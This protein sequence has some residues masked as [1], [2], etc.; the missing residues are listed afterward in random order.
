MSLFRVRRS[1]GPLLAVVKA[2]DTSSALDAYARMRGHLSFARFAYACG[3]PFADAQKAFAI[4]K[5]GTTQA[6]PC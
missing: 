4:E 3:L 2:S 6:Q 1:I 5:V